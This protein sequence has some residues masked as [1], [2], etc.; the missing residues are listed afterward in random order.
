MNMQTYEEVQRHQLITEFDIQSQSELE[1]YQVQLENVDNPTQEQDNLIV[2]VN[3]ESLSHWNESLNFDTWVK[4]NIKGSGKHGLLIHGNVGLFSENSIINTMVFGEDF[5]GSIDWAKWRSTNHTKYSTSSG[6]LVMQDISPTSSQ[7]LQT[8]EPYNDYIV[9][10][11][12]KRTIGTSSGYVLGDTAAIASFTGEYNYLGQGTGLGR[13][14]MN[15]NSDTVGSL[16]DDT[17]YR[18][19]RKIPASGDGYGDI[20]EMDGTILA[21][22]TNTPTSR[23]N[24]IGMFEWQSGSLRYVD[25]VFI[26]KYFTT[27]PTVQIGTTKNISTALKLFGRAG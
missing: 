20:Q 18:L 21:S 25:Y 10:I 8:Y 12:A 1:D 24:Y 7:L 16:S 13:V 23:T 9:T 19:T 6:K 11:K 14:V 2:G 3:G 27:E 26:R 15:G 5:S 17:Y 4:M 22:R